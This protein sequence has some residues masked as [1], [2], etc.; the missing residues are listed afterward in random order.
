MPLPILSPEQK[1]Y[2][3]KFIIAAKAKSLRLSLKM[4]A[5]SL[6]RPVGIVEIFQL[7]LY[8]GENKNAALK[9]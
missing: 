6:G 5:E 9:N 2:D 1:K 3:K 8:R 4:L 7:N